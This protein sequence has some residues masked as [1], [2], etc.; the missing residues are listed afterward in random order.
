M[1]K[2]QEALHVVATESDLFTEPVLFFMSYHGT[3][4]ISVLGV[5]GGV[6][7]FLLNH[8]IDLAFRLLF[9][10]IIL[11]LVGVGPLFNHTFSVVDL[12]SR[13][14]LRSIRSSFHLLLI[15]FL[16]MIGVRG[17][18]FLIVELLSL[19]LHLLKRFLDGALRL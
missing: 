4:S 15:R 12:V 8:V 10:E 1:F 9:L 17:D 16:S 18:L 11:E 2:I 7:E 5:H 19:V 13:V 6:H 3:F 14:L